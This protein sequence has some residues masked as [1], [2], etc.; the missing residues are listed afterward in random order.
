MG[1]MWVLYANDR[2]VHW[3][4]VVVATGEET[5]EDE[6]TDGRF[7]CLL[8]CCTSEEP[9]FCVVVVLPLFLFL[10]FIWKLNLDLTRRLALGYGYIMCFA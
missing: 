1:G 6:R 4:V 7:A 5:S 3:P 9:R 8:F 10:T 2:C